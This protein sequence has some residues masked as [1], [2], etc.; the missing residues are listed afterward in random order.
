MAC[1]R[2]I[3][4]HGLSCAINYYRAVNV[5]VQVMCQSYACI[6]DEERIQIAATSAVSCL[7]QDF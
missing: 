2:L 5:H 6:D 4:L 1:T 7:S 3:I